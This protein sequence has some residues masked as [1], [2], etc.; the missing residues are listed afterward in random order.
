[1]NIAYYP[2]HYGS[3]YLGYSI[4]SI[5]DHVDKIHILYTDKPSHGHGS[6]AVNPDTKQKLIDA[7]NLFGDPKGKIVWHEGRWPNEGA[8]RD[9]INGI[10]ASDNAD[11]IVAVDSDEIWDA[12]VLTKAIEMSVKGGARNNCIRMLTFWRSFGNVCYDEMMPVRVICCKRAPGKTSYLEGR[13]NHFG[14]ARKVEDVAYKI[15]IHGHKNE[16]RGNW[17]DRYKNWPASGNNDLHPTCHNV[18]NASPYDKT[19]L[20]EY[21]RQHPYYNLEVI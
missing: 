13:V 9:T 19:K 14:Y 2:L 15:A 17:F 7:A 18:W 5:Y 10:A 3:D 21:M 11:V 12:D 6:N 1:M 16:W 20:P 4:K 8:Q